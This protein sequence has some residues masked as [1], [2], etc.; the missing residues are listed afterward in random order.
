VQTLYIH[1]HHNNMQES[2]T[3]GKCSW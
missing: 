3:I 1:L 2:I